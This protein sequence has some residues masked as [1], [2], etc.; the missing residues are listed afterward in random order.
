MVYN[1]VMFSEKVI[2]GQNLSDS[3]CLSILEPGQIELLDLLHDAYKLRFKYFGKKVRVHILDNVQNGLCPE[4]CGYCGQAKTSDSKVASYGVKEENLILE[5][6]AKAYAEGAHR[7]CMVLSGRGPSDRNID[8]LTSTIK[9]IKQKYNIKTC[10]SVGLLQEGQA[11][12]LKEAGLDRLNHN[13]NT[14]EKFYPEICSTHTWQDRQQTLSSAREAGIELCSGYILG[15]GESTEDRIA[16]A[17]EASRLKPAS[18]PV[19]FLLPIEGNRINKPQNLSPEIC[20]RLLCLFRYLNPEA[21]I[22]VAAGREYHLRSQ[23]A[24]ALY[25]ANSLFAEGYLLSKGDTASKTLKMIID[26]GFEI[27]SD[28]EI[29]L[30]TEEESFVTLKEEVHVRK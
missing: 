20:L 13:L 17:Q 22:R 19:N 9:N 2:S 23:Q 24:L 30:P 26:S 3:D 4:D 12:R 25:P 14:S 21:E 10:L 1:S 27:E 28:V 5:G 16:M 15:M 7:Y 8:R 11:Q 29:K 18:I 6:A